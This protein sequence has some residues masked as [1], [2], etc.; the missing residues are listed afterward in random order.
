MH[1]MPLLTMNDSLSGTVGA[2]RLPQ[3][4]HPERSE[5]SFLLPR[6]FLATLGMTDLSYLPCL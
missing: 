1:V 3:D 4:C 6:G 5:G 2:S